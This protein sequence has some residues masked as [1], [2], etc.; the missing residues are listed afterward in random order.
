MIVRFTVH[1]ST[2]SGNIGHCIAYMARDLYNL[3]PTKIFLQLFL[4]TFTLFKKVQ[5]V[6]TVP[7]NFYPNWN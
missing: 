6:L 1:S 3:S 5:V 7:T 2:D 4:C